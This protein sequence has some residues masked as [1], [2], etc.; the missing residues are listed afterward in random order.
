MSSDV[1][2]WCADAVTHVDNTAE[3]VED[4]NDCQ[5]HEVDNL[6]TVDVG[7]AAGH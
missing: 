3:D 2:T 7:D 4:A 5:S 6:A 1:I